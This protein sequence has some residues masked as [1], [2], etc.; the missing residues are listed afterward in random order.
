MQCFV[1]NVDDYAGLS[2]EQWKEARALAAELYQQGRINAATIRFQY[3]FRGRGVPELKALL[4]DKQLGY[5]D[6][7]A[8]DLGVGRDHPREERKSKYTARLREVAEMRLNQLDAVVDLTPNQKTKLGFAARRTI[9]PQAIKKK[10]D[11]QDLFRERDG[12]LEVTLILMEESS[13]ANE[14]CIPG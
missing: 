4:T 14:S 2:N 5:L 10:L 3:S 11:A 8:T 13:R 7:A 12:G 6:K 9:V 1:Q